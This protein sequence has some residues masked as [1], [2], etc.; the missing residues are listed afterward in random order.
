MFLLG[1]GLGCRI[2]RHIVEY[3]AYR[4]GQIDAIEGRLEFQQVKGS[5]GRVYYIK[6]EGI[7]K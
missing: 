2:E 7:Y 5:D 1:I 3:D 6:L 4:Q